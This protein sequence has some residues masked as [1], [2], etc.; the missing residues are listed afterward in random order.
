[1]RTAKYVS[2]IT[3]TDPDTNEPIEITVFKEEGGGMF[4]VDASFIEQCLGDENPAVQNP[5]QF[6]GFVRLV[7]PE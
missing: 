6:D 5:I 3:V 7:W 1:M 4:A 2:D